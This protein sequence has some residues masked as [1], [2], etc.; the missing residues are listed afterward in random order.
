MARLLST[1]LLLLLSGCQLDLG[2]A[3][4][5][6][7]PPTQD[8]RCPAGYTCKSNLCI[9]DG[10]CPAILPECGSSSNCPNGACEADK[11]E[12]LATCP[13]DCLCGNKTCD[14]DKGETCTSCPEDCGECP[15]KCNNKKCETGETPQ[16]CPQDC[17]ASQCPNNRC[18]Q[19]ETEQSCPQDCKNTGC[20]SDETKCENKETLQYCE[21]GVWKTDSCD[22]LC[23]AG[24][25]DYG[26]G[27][28][29]DA[30]KS[31]NVCLCGKFGG[32]GTICDDKAL[33]DPKYF[34]GYFTENKPGFCSFNCPA[35]NTTC[36]GAP[37]GTVS[38]CVLKVG[39]QFACGFLCDSTPCPPG[40]NCDQASKLCKP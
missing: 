22:A 16:N 11:G 37:T 30:A 32:L 35:A 27:C 17:P 39:G 14:T 31:K 25:F 20:A 5:R 18:E 29:Y 23:K 33:C 40:L 15:S 7:G 9:L 3:P 28:E 8:P 6:C 36:S 24:Q 38:K 21:S 12:T 1:L 2:S 4:F 34:C 19:D 13:Q 10:S 26:A